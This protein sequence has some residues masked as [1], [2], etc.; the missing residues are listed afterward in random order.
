MKNLKSYDEF[1]NEGLLDSITLGHVIYGNAKKTTKLGGKIIMSIK[2]NRTTTAHVSVAVYY[3]PDSKTFPRVQF[4]DKETYPNLGMA[5]FDM[6]WNNKK[7]S[8]KVNHFNNKF[9][10]AVKASNLEELEAGKTYTDKEMADI[11]TKFF[12][13]VN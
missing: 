5:N 1:L 8:W 3:D 11:L 6:E 10:E 2:S 13:T 9:P 4:F 7:D 12:N